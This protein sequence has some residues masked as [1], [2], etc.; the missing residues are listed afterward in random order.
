[1]TGKRRGAWG[2]HL[3]LLLAAGWLMGLGGGNGGGSGSA[4]PLPQENFTVTVSDAAGKSLEAKR[5]TWEGKVYLRAQV[6]NATVSL[7]FAKIRTVSVLP[8]NTTTAP[9][10]IRAGVTLK[11]GESVEVLIERGSKCYGQTKFGDYEI[12]FKDIA[13][14]EFR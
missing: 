5:F 8:G 10:L 1:M 11:N 14:I 13:K 7:P 12:F 2:R 9:D 6:G 3:A 4:I